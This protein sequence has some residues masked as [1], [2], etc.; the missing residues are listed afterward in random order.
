MFA[1]GGLSVVA[2]GAAGAAAGAEGCPALRRCPGLARSEVSVG[3]AA[4]L[5]HRWEAAVGA[6]PGGRGTRPA[7][8]AVCVPQQAAPAPALPGPGAGEHQPRPRGRDPAAGYPLSPV[9]T[10]RKAFGVALAA[11]SIVGKKKKKKLGATT[12]CSLT[13]EPSGF[14]CHVQQVQFPF[15]SPCLQYSR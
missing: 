8:R 12:F 4:A 5:P 9:T 11:R 14:L 3:A 1:V 6:G 10:P 15:S 7:L 2:G 13:A